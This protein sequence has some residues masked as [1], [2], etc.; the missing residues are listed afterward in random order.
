MENLQGERDA[1][2][3]GCVFLIHVHLSKIIPDVTGSLLLAIIAS[4]TG[5]YSL[6]LE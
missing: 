5:K 6:V 3:L 1:V 2:K 4:R